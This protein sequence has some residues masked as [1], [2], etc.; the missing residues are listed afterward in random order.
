MQS[1]VYPHAS[2]PATARAALRTVL[3]LTP[4]LAL[5]STAPLVVAGAG[6]CL[7]LLIML[8]WQGEEPPILLLPVLFQWSEVAIV[9]L[10]T[11]WLGVPLDALS[12]HGADLY[13]STSFGLCGVAALGTGMRLGLGR[14]RTMSPFAERLRLNA[15]HWGYRDVLR[16]T[17]AAMIG[18][19]ALTAAANWAGPAREL[20]SHSGSIR[21]VGIFALTY[22][23]ILH[24][25]HYG[26]LMAMV[27]FEALFGMTGFFAGFKGSLLT[28]LVAAAAARPNLRRGDAIV[29]GASAAALL[30]VAI[31]W[32]AVK[33]DY[34]SF[35]NQDTGAQAVLVPLADR[36]AYLMQS[37]VSFDLTELT[38]GFNR[39]VA[40]HGY[41]EFLG[42]VMQNVPANV[43]H[44]NGNLTFAVVQHISMPRFLFP[45]KPPL[46][47]DTEVM[48]RYSGLLY[49]WNDS[50]S[51]SIGYLG[52]LYI[53]F[54][55]LGGLL[56]A[57]VIGVL[58]GA[59]YRTVSRRGRAPELLV[60]GLCVGAALP[61]AYFG[62]AYAKMMGAF[63]FSAIWAVM[64][65]KA[66]PTLLPRI[67][68]GRPSRGRPVA[69]F[70]S[71]H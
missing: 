35:V 64:W 24:R 4:V 45:G 19:Y 55:W 36:I 56:A 10:S 44:E 7:A 16:I 18:G 38:D 29:I 49:T 47:S 58:G 40:R 61:L 3:L 13:Q 2:R 63:V 67:L 5:L 57:L 8:L 31:F 59:V 1:M 68:G 60:A 52:E 15:L 62:T 48:A 26:P 71:R 9:P 12:Q 54:G 30:L 50:T 34:R 25:K 21:F 70:V 37:L 51:I 33:V 28:V 42:L 23:C 11:I 6:I 22:W 20:L 65:K 46:P 69:A 53:D 66:M 32:S 27:A 41:V 39:L 14:G 17:L 43:P